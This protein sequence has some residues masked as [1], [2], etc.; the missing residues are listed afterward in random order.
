MVVEVNDDTTQF[1][2]EVAFG[3]DQIVRD[4]KGIRK[5]ETTVSAVVKGLVP[6]KPE[7][8]EPNPSY[9]EAIKWRNASETTIRK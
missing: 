3:L 8:A 5:S 2:N 4:C 1:Y 9:Q 7:T 6:A